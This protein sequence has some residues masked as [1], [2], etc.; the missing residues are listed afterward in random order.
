MVEHVI[1]APASKM[2]SETESLCEANKAL[3]GFFALLRAEFQLGA[4]C[5][6]VD[7]FGVVIT[8]GASW[9]IPFGSFFLN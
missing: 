9:Y 1:V 2:I 4:F 8:Y 7:G 6:R 5:F 3:V